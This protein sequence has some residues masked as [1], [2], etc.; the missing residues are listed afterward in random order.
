MENRIHAIAAM[1]AVVLAIANVTPRARAPGAMPLEGT[2]W[3]A[4]EL[5]G[6]PIL[7]PADRAPYL[8][9]Q[10]EKRVSGSDGCNRITGSYEL[11]GAAVTFGQMASTRMACL[12]IGE[13]DRAFGVA[14]NSARRLKVVGDR[15]ELSDAAGRRV[16][17][18]RAADQP[19]APAG[20]R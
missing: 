5:G 6:K 9:F 4:I 19:R 14:L 11:K 7:S 13:V 1:T 15:L 10:A 17:I 8:I 20:S 2:Y 16:A 18:F 12:D 3:K